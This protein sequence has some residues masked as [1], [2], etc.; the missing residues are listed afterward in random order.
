MGLS[1]PPGLDNISPDVKIGGYSCLESEKDL[2]DKVV[3][4]SLLGGEHRDDAL[5][6]VKYTLVMDGLFR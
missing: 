2:S 3:R 6:V 4:H 1:H 5:Q